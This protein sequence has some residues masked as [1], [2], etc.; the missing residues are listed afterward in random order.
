MRLEKFLRKFVDTFNFAT[1]NWTPAG[2][3]VFRAR[4]KET[5]IEKFSLGKGFCHWS[6]LQ[7]EEHLKLDSNFRLGFSSRYGKVILLMLD[8]DTDKSSP[9]RHADLK[10]SMKILKDKLTNVY[11]ENAT[12]SDD[13]HGYILVKR[14]AM[15]SARKFRE[16]MLSAI[17]VLS[18]ELPIKKLE[19]MGLPAQY[20]WGKSET[21]KNKDGSA[22]KLIVKVKKS[23][24]IAKVPRPRTGKDMKR[25]LGLKTIDVSLF[26]MIISSAEAASEDEVRSAPQTQERPEVKNEEVEDILLSGI[27]SQTL[28][29]TSLSESNTKTFIDLWELVTFEDRYCMLKQSQQKNG[30]TYEK[31]TYITKTE[32]SDYCLAWMLSVTRFDR[33]IE[34]RSANL[35]ST[36][37]HEWI[38]AEYEQQSGRKVDQKK[39]RWVMT[40]LLNWGILLGRNLK[41]TEGVSRKFG[42]SWNR[43]HALLK[44]G[45]SLT[46]SMN[47]EA[48]ILTNE[49][50]LA[51]G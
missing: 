5:L 15:Y 6:K 43:L 1:Y 40:Q 4:T 3:E 39:R 9:T 27:K 41:W 32:W 34:D 22:K 46:F 10:A 7:L 16:V 25:L 11:F 50:T 33:M 14:P 2:K 26:E 30:K 44:D 31:N 8:L 37:H 13:K 38:D 35:T 17:K 47:A 12:Y 51:E 42:W 29:K 49:G 24:I 23:G 20:V 45:S 21:L 19:I 18:R 36:V 48:P 28:N